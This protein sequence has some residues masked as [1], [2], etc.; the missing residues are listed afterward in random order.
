MMSPGT[1]AGAGCVPSTPSRQTQTWQ[2]GQEDA[3]G[4]IVRGW[5]Q[6]Q[7]FTTHGFDRRFYELCVLINAFSQQQ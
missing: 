6:D 4:G 3:R 2:P 1:N 7:A 5:R